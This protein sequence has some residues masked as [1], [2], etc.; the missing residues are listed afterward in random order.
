MYLEICLS[1]VIEIFCSIKHLTVQTRRRFNKPAEGLL[2][3]N[4]VLNIL[5]SV[6]HIKDLNLPCFRFQYFFYKCTYCVIFMAGCLCLNEVAG[7]LM[8]F[9]S[10]KKRHS[11]LQIIGAFI[12]FKFCM[13]HR[14]T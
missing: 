13:D 5:V 8:K 4:Y 11:S 10:R 6:L 12:C 7:L 1:Y 2:T 3:C 14:L 9:N